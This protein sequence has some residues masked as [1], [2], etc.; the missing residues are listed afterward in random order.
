M[1][2]ILITKTDH[3][4]ATIGITEGENLTCLEAEFIY[5]LTVAVRQT[6]AEACELP[7]AEEN[8]EPA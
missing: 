2:Q 6:E 8:E 7:E 1:I 4:P 5:A 3:Q